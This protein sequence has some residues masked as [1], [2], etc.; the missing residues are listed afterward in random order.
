MRSDGTIRIMLQPIVILFVFLAGVFAAVHVLAVSLSLYWYWWWFDS[1]MHFWGGTLIT[2]GLFAIATFSRFRTKPTLLFTL[3][4][5]LFFT[6]TW[7]VFE[8]LVGLVHPD[9]TEHMID[10]AK[11][12]ILGFVGGLITF[13]L[14]RRFRI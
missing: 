5:L 1:V 6:V 2:L 4:V 7:E 8:L 13:A 9:T 11:D 12:I 14:L 3:G 10:T